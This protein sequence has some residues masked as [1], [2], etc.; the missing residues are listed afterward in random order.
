M[1]PRSIRARL[2]LWYTSLL[3][4][5]VL[6]LG[7]VAYGLV[8]YSL[9]HDVDTALQ[10]I[11]QVLAERPAASSSALVPADIDA[12]FRRFFGLSPWDRY[13]EQQRP[14][15][16]QALGAPAPRTGQLPLSATA[17]R[18]VAQGLATFET[19][20]GLGRYPVRVLTRPVLAGGRS[21]SLLQVGMSLESV[22]MARRRFLLAT[23]AVLP[24]ALLLASGGGWLLA[25]RALQPVD[26]MTEA[27][28]RISAEQLSARLETTATNDELERLAETLNAMLSRLDAAFRQVRQFSADASH[29]LQTPLTILKGELEVALRAP[30]SPEEYQRVLASALEE[31]E[32]LAS[33]VDGLLLLARADAGVL[34]MERQPVDLALLVEEVGAQVRMLADA[35]ALTLC[36]G[37]VEPLIIQ[38]D[39][40]HLR[41]LLLNLVDNSLKYTPPGGQVTLTVQRQDTWAALHVSDTGIGLSPD[42]Q[43]H[44]FQRFY[45]AAHAQVRE[46]GGAGLGLCIAHSIVQAHG[47]Y[48]QVESAPGCGSTFTVFLP[49]PDAV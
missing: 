7:G 14:G 24:L 21:T 45:R 19:V 5:T 47:G 37:L 4:V 12:L 20:E 22:T 44:I 34:R 25:R 16:G 35:H 2:T 40:A 39:H 13:V 49:L 33:L 42:E 17:V 41:R 9:V 28:R 48:M 43:A 31:C 36:Y 46:A 29:E 38:G 1:R 26:R 18:R 23:A 15:D 32:R 8:E 27:A 6:L 11:A 10:S 30:R 3:T